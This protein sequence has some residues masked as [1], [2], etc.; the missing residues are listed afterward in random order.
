MKMSVPFSMAEYRR[1]ALLRLAQD[2][3][4]V[5]MTRAIEALERLQTG[6]YGYCVA[7]GIKMPE[8][9]LEARPERRR[10]SSCAA[11]AAA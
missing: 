10:C 7:C 8:A 4:P 3:D 1:E 2:S 11:V 9:S 5:R 6:A